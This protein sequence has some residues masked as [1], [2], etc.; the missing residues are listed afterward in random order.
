MYKCMYVS[1]SNMAHY[2]FENDPEVFSKF[3]QGM[4]KSDN[5][6]TLKDITEKRNLAL[7]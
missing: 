2:V 3:S 5:K 6:F 4:S 1:F 7:D